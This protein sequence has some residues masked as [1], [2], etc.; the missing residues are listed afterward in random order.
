MKDIYKIDGHKLYW[1]L[2]RLREWQSNRAVSPV[3]IE[4]SPVSFCNHRCVFCGVDFAMQN[5]LKLDTEL[6]CTR[7]REMGRLGV[8]SVMFAGEGEPL[9]HP[10]LPVFVRTAKE[11]G[12]DVAITSNGTLGNKQLWNEM[13]PYLTWIKFSIDAGSA[14]VYSRVHCVPEAL[15]EKTLDSIRAAVQVKK[16]REL[17][18]TIG[19]QFL[20]IE[21]N[22]DDVRNALDLFASVGVDY[23]VLK[24]YSLHPQMK[25]KKD[26]LYTDETIRS[27]Q[28]TVDDFKKKNSGM[29]IIFR[30]VATGKYGK[31]EKQYQHCYALPFWGYVSS[32]GDFYTCSVYI[33]DE[34]FN[35]GNVYTD[36]MEGILFGGKRIKSIENGEKNLDVS[37]ECRVNCRMSRINEFLEFLNDSPEHVNFI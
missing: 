4:I 20:L 15:F 14:A 7:L 10:D 13:L 27:L 23:I 8:R 36:S 12:I 26:I 6:L 31:M 3:Y 29:R 18:V 9:L 22:M 24:P 34:R 35:V 2:D 32:N 25:R 16:T 37:K 1:H 5:R 17:A 21:E 33:G 11:S 28:D 30:N 19:A